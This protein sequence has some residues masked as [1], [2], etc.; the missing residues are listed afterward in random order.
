MNRQPG[1]FK[2]LAIGDIADQETD[3]VLTAA[4]WRLNKGTGADGTIQGGPRIYDECLR[5]VDA[6]APTGAV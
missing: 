4:H 3:A 5:I 1:S 6:P 2:R